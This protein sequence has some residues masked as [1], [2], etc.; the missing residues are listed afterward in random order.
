MVKIS[1]SPA[2][3]LVVHEVVEA[4]RDD[5]LLER[6]TPQG[7][8]PLYWCNGILF[9]FSSVPMTEEII[10]EYLKGRIHWL[11]VHFTRMD[12]HVPVISFESPE[13]RSTM[14]VKVI[15]T[16]ASELHNEFVRWL[17]TY[18]KKK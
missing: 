1:F 4:T 14:N 8:M 12:K 9:S 2:T 15:D 10:K 5:L 6:I 7:N 3:E 13:Y 17:K 18:A 16:S 11:E